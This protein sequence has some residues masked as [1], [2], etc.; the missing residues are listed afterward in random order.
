[1]TLFNK[2][3]APKRDVSSNLLFSIILLRSNMNAVFFNRVYFIQICQITFCKSASS[4]Y[5]VLK[6]GAS[7]NSKNKRTSVT[8]WKVSFVNGG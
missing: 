7:I 6:V 4:T 2:T 1:M 5:V 3:P 8:P